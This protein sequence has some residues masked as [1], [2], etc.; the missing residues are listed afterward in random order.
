MT[1]TPRPDPSAD[2]TSVGENGL[3][4]ALGGDLDY[5]NADAFV[6]EVA[7]RL[8]ARPEATDLRLS[9]AGLGHIDSMGLSALLMIRRHARTARVQLHLDERPAHLERLLRLTGTLDHL[10]GP[11]GTE[12][13]AGSPSAPTD[14]PS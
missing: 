5:E 8:S 4:I 14:G 13:G 9:C 7:A 2:T 3:H 10:T 11:D 12:R 6:R 1:T